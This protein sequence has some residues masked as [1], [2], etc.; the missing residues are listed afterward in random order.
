MSVEELASFDAKKFRDILKQ[1]LGSFAVFDQFVNWKISV[2][3]LQDDVK[4]NRVFATDIKKDLDNF[5]ENSGVLNT[6]QNQRLAAIEAQLSN[7]PF[8]G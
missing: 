3:K 8:P 2:D 4:E 5:K 1:K 6:S 7:T